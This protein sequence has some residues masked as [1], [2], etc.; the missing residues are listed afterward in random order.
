[1]S[2]AV[3]G[4]ARAYELRGSDGRR[5]AAAGFAAHLVKPADPAQVHA[6]LSKGLSGRA[7]EA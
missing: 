2:E 1:M 3:A 7:P 4:E 5:S 6:C